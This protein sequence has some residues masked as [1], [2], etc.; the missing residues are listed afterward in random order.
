MDVRWRI[1]ALRPD[2][3][4]EDVCL[5]KH[6]PFSSDLAT[7]YEVKVQAA[8][9]DPSLLQADS[10]PPEP[11]LMLE[12]FTQTLHEAA[13]DFVGLAKQKAQQHCSS[14]EEAAQLSDRQKQLRVQIAACKDP[15]RWEALKTK[16]RKV[17]KALV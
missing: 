16:R 6:N 7:Q 10:G 11:T 3:A 12:T 4:S 15:V 13:A 5:R 17:T 9:P 14:S 2:Q 1:R 8:L